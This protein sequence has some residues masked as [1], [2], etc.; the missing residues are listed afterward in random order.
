M[1]PKRPDPEEYRMANGHALCLGWG[2][3]LATAP[4]GSRNYCGRA[5]RRRLFFR[6][7]LPTAEFVGFVRHE[8]NGNVRGDEEGE[9]WV[10]TYR[11]G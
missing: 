2:G 5:A 9:D 11:S 3:A 4:T 7:S 6:C 1:H 10:M 8:A